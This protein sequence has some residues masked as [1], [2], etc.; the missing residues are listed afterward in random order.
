MP[1]AT[2][3]G[4]FVIAQ[5]QPQEEGPRLRSFPRQRTDEEEDELYVLV[6][7]AT[8]AGEEYCGQLVEAI[9]KVYRQESLSLTGAVLRAVRAAH[10]QL[11]DWNQRTLREQQ[12]TAGV[13]CLAVRGRTAYVAQVGPSV[14]YHV[15]DGHVEPIVPANGTGELLGSAD[16]T[17]P[18]FSRYQLSP[19]DLLLL[20]SP[21][22]AE[23]ID[24]QTLRAV[25][26]RGPDEALVELFRL[27]R[28]QQEFALVLLS[29]VVEPEAET[30]PPPL[31]P[32]ADGAPGQASQAG[33]SVWETGAPPATDVP[34]AEAALSGAVDTQPK[35]RLKGDAAGIRYPPTTG[36][37][38]NLP[39]VPPL[40]VIALLALAVIGLV[41][42][43]ALPP[44]LDRSRDEAYATLVEDARSA[45]LNAQQTE[46]PGQRRGLLEEANEKLSEAE[47]RQTGDPEVINLRAQLDTALQDLDAER[48]LDEPSLIVDL[49]ASVPAPVSADTL[50][51]G[52]G[53]AYLLDS[54]Q[55]RVIAV[56]LLA[57]SADPFPVYG[58]GGLVGTEI[59]GPPERIAWAEGLG[60][61]LVLDDA[62]RLIA[63][64]PGQ[65]PRPL[66]LRDADAWASADAIAYANGNLYVLD[67]AGDQIWRYLPTD[68]GFDSEREPLLS[69]IDLDQEAEIAIGDAL[70]LASMD[71]PVRRI[72]GGEEQPFLQA[73]IDR[74]LASPAS[75]V[76]LPASQRLLVADRGNKR[77]VVFSPEGTFLQQFASPAFN[78][79]RAIAVDEANGLLYVLDGSA[80]YRTQLPAAP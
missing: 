32:S 15:G 4:R 75:P 16:L 53:G 33:A 3:V 17:Q 13:S 69:S 19:G 5:G 45:L 73:G 28:D 18:N 63:V 29:C 36:L 25:L 57:P 76:F 49:S 11:L 80:L 43:C 54:E 23:L 62:R 48:V 1:V 31:D 55:D 47:G 30:A 41:G 27:A 22:L 10:Q 51:L 74:A 77:I 14:A 70:Y 50:A 2:R 38:A 6:E 21:R 78:D 20:A 12:V 67:R 56:S 64:T 42:W 26:L 44:A 61:L 37:R 52:G 40:A 71:G 7:P 65:A 58:A 34:V 60:A 8:S 24:E 35:V 59:T 66:T 46:D 72:Q 68:G 9:G 79:L 39:R